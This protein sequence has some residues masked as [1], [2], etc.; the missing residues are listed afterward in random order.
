MNRVG[1][2]WYL[3]MDV[4]HHGPGAVEALPQ[5]LARL[6][7]TRAMVVSS[8][9]VG[10]SPALGGRVR[11]LLGQ[12]FV[13][14][15]T[16]VQ[17]H[18]P[19]SCLQSGLDLVR[20]LQPDVLVTL[21]AGSVVD[22]GRALALAAGEGLRDADDLQRFRALY[23]PPDSTTIPATS[24]RALPIIAVPTTLSA[25]E[26]A[27]AGAVTS[28]SRGTKDLLIADELTP[29]SVLLDPEI[30][31]T[32]PPQLWVSTGM[33]ALDHAVET[34]YSPRSGAVTDA[35]SLERCATQQQRDGN[36][37]AV[38]TQSLPFK[39]SRACT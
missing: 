11:E 20:E 27:N 22:A 10:A 8:P 25:A 14:M 29:R 38:C 31:L 37:N 1:Q 35:L 15:F 13:G 9:T 24:G 5:E 39:D 28:E 36:G 34:I 32:T 33:R 4:V 21:G 18:V 30:A 26:F 16:G 2:F 6:G 7:V 3:P 19:Y 12:H 23:T 17:P